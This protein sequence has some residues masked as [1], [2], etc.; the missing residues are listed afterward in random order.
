MSK[1]FLV[2]RTEDQRQSIHRKVFIHFMNRKEE[3]KRM[4]QR[5]K[6]RIKGSVLEYIKY[7]YY[8]V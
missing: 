2:W 4:N 7:S 3:N 5:G 6:I 8:N 1:Q